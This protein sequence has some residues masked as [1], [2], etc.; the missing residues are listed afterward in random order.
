MWVYE[1]TT[2]KM[3]HDDVVVA[4]GYSGAG[5]DKNKP[6]D[7]S[8]K[9]M[10]PLPEGTYSIGDPIDTEEHGPYVL[11][12]T[13]DASNKMYGR[14]GFLIHGDKKKAPGTASKGCIILPHDARVAIHVSGDKV[15]EVKA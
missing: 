1:I 14:F 3:R 9:D 6:E 4:I 15:L 11:P 13:P 10:G 5:D 8:V 2:G 12:L 7:E